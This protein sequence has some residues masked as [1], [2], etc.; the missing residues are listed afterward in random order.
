MILLCLL[1]LAGIIIPTCSD[2]FIESTMQFMENP[3]IYISYAWSKESERL[4]DLVESVLQKKNYNVKRDKNAIHY[5]GNIDKFQRRLDRSNYIVVV[6]SDSFLKSKNCMLEML[7]IKGHEDVWKRIFPI[8]LDDGRGIYEEQGRLSYFTYWKEKADKFEKKLNKADKVHVGMDRNADDLDNLKKIQ[9]LINTVSTVL[10]KMNTLTAAQHEENN[11]S[12]L[13]KAIEKQMAEDDGTGHPSGSSIGSPE[14]CRLSAVEPPDYF[15]GR[16]GPLKILH[17]KLTGEEPLLL[18]NGL[19]GIGKT[20]M[21]QAYVN[22]PEYSGKYRHIAWLSAETGIRSNMI[23]TLTPVLDLNLYQYTP[24]EH[25]TILTY[26]MGEIPGPNL[27]VI[28]NANEVEPLRN[29][30][31]EL[32]ALRWNVL[33]TSR[34]EIDGYNRMRVD[35]LELKDARKL[36]LHHFSPEK[37]ESEEMDLLDV[38]LEKVYF[39]TLLIKLLAKAGRKKR[40]TI[41]ELKKRIDSVNPRHEFFLAQHHNREPYG[42]SQQKKTKHPL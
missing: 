35:Q 10:D 5:K 4:T 32:L 2:V 25:F 37:Q 36:F 40:L 18:I 26:R 7:Y 17:E 23:R 20:S 21:A 30:R 16:E 9:M 6:I 15:I 12:E 3:D 29:L 27:L 13:I 19:G 42:R 31:D 24:D 38:L 33:I 34:C 11:F 28:D 8:V 22:H 39:N 1:S 14:P 41:G